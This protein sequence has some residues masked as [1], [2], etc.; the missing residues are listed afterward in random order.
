MVAA[1]TVRPGR[2]A[3]GQRYV[4]SPLGHR[5]RTRNALHRFGPSAPGR[6]VLAVHALF[7]APGTASAV[8]VDCTHRQAAEGWPAWNPLRG[9]AL[10]S[11]YAAETRTY[12]RAA[13]VFAFSRWAERSL[14]KDYGVD[15]E[16]VS[17]VGL[18][19]NFGAQPRPPRR[20]GPPTVLLVGHDLVRKGG[21][22]LLRAFA[23]VRREVPD[24]R[25]RLVGR[26]PR[27][28]RLPA[29]VESLGPVDRAG[30]ASLM[31][32]ADVFALP[33]LFDPMPHALL[34]AMA[35]GLPVVTT[36]TCGIPE[37]VED[38]VTGRLV[39]PGDA[40]GLAATLVRCLTQPGRDAALGL[41]GQARVEEAHQW[42]HV[43]HRMA[44]ALDRLL[45]TAR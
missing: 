17:V 13:H 24:A 42:D 7:E 20:P 4:K 31:Q 43:V 22:V 6:P 33:S 25:L 9:N 15:P 19:A 12:Q 2:E 3:W 16:Q 14:V 34:E 44:P 29:G 41:T 11:W 23:D 36:R 32:R 28:G 27:P 35:H 39:D 30:V 26:H 5:L 40:A 10:R 1:L 8:Y 21:E 45:G 38:G 37:F 18:G